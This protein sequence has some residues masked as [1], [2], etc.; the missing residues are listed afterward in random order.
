MRVRLQ[1]LAKWSE[2]TSTHGALRVIRLS[3]RRF[4]VVREG[5]GGPAAVH[6]LCALALS[7]VHGF[8]PSV[9]SGPKYWCV[10]S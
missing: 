1:A 5:D 2:V 3:G 6:T 10:A 8:A 7:F 4:V 9:K